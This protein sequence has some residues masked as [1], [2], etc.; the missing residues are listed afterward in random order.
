MNYGIHVY[1]VGDPAQSIY[2]F[3]GAR[4]TN[5]TNFGIDP[6]S[7]VKQVTLRV[8]D[9]TLTKSWRFGPKVAAIANTILFSKQFS[10]QTASDL[11]KRSWIP[12]RLTGCD[13]DSRVTMKSLLPEVDKKRLTVLAFSNIELLDVALNALIRFPDLKIAIAGEGANSGKNS[14]DQVDKSLQDFYK[15]FLGEISSLPE[16]Y[17]E[18]SDEGEIT[19]LQVKGNCEER[20]LNKYLQ[21]IRLIEKYT[22]STLEK[23]AEFK[24]KVMILNHHA[25]DETV[26]L[27]LSTIHAA[28]G[29][30]W[31]RVEIAD[32]SLCDIADFQY[33]PTINSP[34]LISPLKRPR[35]DGETNKYVS[36]VHLQAEF[37]YV[38]WGDAVNLWYV[39]LTRARKILSVP[40]KFLMLMEIFTLV[41]KNCNPELQCHNNEEGVKVYDV[42]EGDD[43]NESRS[44][45]SS[46]SQLF[47]SPVSTQSQ[48]N[49]YSLSLTPLVSSQSA[50]V[51]SIQQQEAI[52]RS[53]YLKWKGEMNRQGGLIIDECSMSSL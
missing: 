23:F 43:T 24:Q 51:L 25:N 33:S 37:D 31:D 39:A 35:I 16:S 18:W 52:Y 15:L 29:L 21:I 4:S 27:V 3:R 14:W 47:A 13:E 7:S 41:A 30:E 10:P 1:I 32:G 22:T 45:M 20:E 2:S 50:S 46:S 53:L 49:S 42:D 8:V 36:E 40:P 28:K 11:S 38:S 19:W 5:L 26:N 17:T 9:K 48:S 44:M 34:I 6:V 12:Y